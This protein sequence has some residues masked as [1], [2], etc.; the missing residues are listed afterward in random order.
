[1]KRVLIVEDE[2]NILTSL[3]FVLERDGFSVETVANG[4]E[5]IDKVRSFRP[6]LVI[7]DIMLP[8]RS[9]YEICHEMQQDPELKSIPTLMLTAKAQEAERRKGMEVGATAY[10]TKPFRVAELRSKIRSILGE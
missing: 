8:A 3:V 1:M 2:M 10:I 5:A 7:L 4:S 6:D 9:G